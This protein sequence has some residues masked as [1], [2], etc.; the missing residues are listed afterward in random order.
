MTLTAG[1]GLN[2]YEILSPLGRG[3][4]GKVFLAEDTRLLRKVALKLLPEEFSA[5]TSDL[6]R[7]RV[8]RRRGV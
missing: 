1:A 8:R 2:H 5:G 4:M 6:Y 3:G 7:A